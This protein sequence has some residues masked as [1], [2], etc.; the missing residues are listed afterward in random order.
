MHQE[1]GIS[2][3]RAD[4]KVSGG[5]LIRVRAWHDGPIIK[6]VRFNG[7]FFAHPEEAV[8]ELEDSLQ[9]VRFAES[10]EI[11]RSFFRQNEVI[12]ASAED[13]ISALKIAL[14]EL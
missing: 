7:D 13:F 5:K 12:G 4:Y 10:F 3:G 8:E 9:D 11:I 14:G 1:N 6:K 2:E